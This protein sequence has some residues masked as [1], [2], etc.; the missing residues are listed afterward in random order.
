MNVYNIDTLRKKKGI[1]LPSIMRIQE[2]LKKAGLYSVSKKCF[3]HK[4]IV[5]LVR[6]QVRRGQA[7]GPAKLTTPTKG[8]GQW[9]PS[10]GCQVW[11]PS[12]CGRG[13]QEEHEPEKREIQEHEA[14]HRSPDPDA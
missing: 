10:L 3:V 5:Q 12:I 8:A 11:V 4:C 9:H 2:C 1:V 14:M 7:K 13:V 6:V